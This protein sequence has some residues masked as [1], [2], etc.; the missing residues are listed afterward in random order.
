MRE[1]FAAVLL[2]W[3][4]SLGAP[5]LAATKDRLPTEQMFELVARP[6]S[7]AAQGHLDQADKLFEAQLANVQAEKGATSIEAADLLHAMGIALWISGQEAEEPDLRGAAVPYLRRSVQVAKAA[8]GPRHLEVALALN[9]YAVAAHQLCAQPPPADLLA[10]MKEAYAI[11][12][13]ALGGSNP[14]TKQTLE[15]VKQIEK[16][17]APISTTPTDRHVSTNVIPSVDQP[18]T[19]D[20]TME[21]DWG[22]LPLMTLWGRGHAILAVTAL[23]MVVTAAMLRRRRLV[24]GLLVH[25]GLGLALVICLTLM[26]SRMPGASLRSW[27][28]SSW[29]SDVSVPLIVWWVLVGLVAVGVGRMIRPGASLAPIAALVGRNRGKALTVVV[30]LLLAMIVRLQFEVHSKRVEISCRHAELRFLTGHS[31]DY[32]KRPDCEVLDVAHELTKF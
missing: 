7:A 16:P 19:L 25:V 27:A 17:C 23:S 21:H 1:W 8:W 11:R 15:T 24:P 10:S 20:Q 22:W 28:L 32:S 29:N 13:E 18:P 2:L 31:S 12:L 30:L 6:L 26:V 14:E 5:A 4:M 9:D 3:L